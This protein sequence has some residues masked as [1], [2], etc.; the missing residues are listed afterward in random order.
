VRQSWKVG[1]SGRAVGDEKTTPRMRGIPT[2][3]AA[4]KVGDTR[5]GEISDARLIIIPLSSRGNTVRERYRSN[6]GHNLA[7]TGSGR[8]VTFFRSFPNNTLPAW[9]LLVSFP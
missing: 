2:V 7:Q 3:L 6:G 4:D 9:L 5:L 8:E 1:K